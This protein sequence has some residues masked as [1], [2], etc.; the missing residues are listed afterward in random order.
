[1]KID[2]KSWR[3][4]DIYYVG[5]FDKKPDWNVNSVNPFYLIFNRVYGSVTE[6]YGNKFLSIEKGDA[7]SKKI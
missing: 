7:V 2:K 6:K 3:D 1:M 5:Y 4:I